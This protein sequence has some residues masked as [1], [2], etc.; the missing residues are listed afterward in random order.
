MQKPQ[1]NK[2]IKQMLRNTNKD[3][4]K[5]QSWQEPSKDRNYPAQNHTPHIDMMWECNVCIIHP[6]PIHPPKPSTG[7]HDITPRTEYTGI[8]KH[9]LK[10]QLADLYFH[11]ENKSHT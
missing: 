5:T 10:H 4:T 8:S 9:E 7:H 2:L 1:R 11:H 6:Q 3:S